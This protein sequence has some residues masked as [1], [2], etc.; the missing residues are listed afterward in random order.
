[1]IYSQW[2]K[3]KIS[4]SVTYKSW[5]KE[6]LPLHAQQYPEDGIKFEKNK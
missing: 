1:M 5:L 2:N 6:S 3:A 4:K